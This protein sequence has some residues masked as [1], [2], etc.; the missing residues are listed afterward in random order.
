MIAF[1]NVSEILEKS[2]V[3]EEKL[4]DLYDVAEVATRREESG[5]VV[6]LLRDSLVQKL[7]VLRNVD[8][9]K[10]GTLEWVRYAGDRNEADLLASNSIRRDSPP[11][12]I[13]NHL[14]TYQQH[15]QDFYAHIAENLVSRDQKELFESLASFKAEQ[16]GEIG[17]IV[18]LID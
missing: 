4:K 15:L 14:V 12:D 1:K 16:I 11:E 5:K 6:A 2:L 8:P 18:S 7:K 3:W 10:F 17:R 13:L 9:S